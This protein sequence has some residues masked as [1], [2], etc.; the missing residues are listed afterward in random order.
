MGR[1]E[2]SVPSRKAGVLDGGQLEIP[3]VTPSQGS[4]ET[5]LAQGSCQSASPYLSPNLQNCVRAAIQSRSHRVRIHATWL[6]PAEI[7][8][9]KHHRLPPVLLSRQWRG[10]Q[11]HS[12]QES[13]VLYWP[14]FCSGGVD[15][16]PTLC[17]NQR[18]DP[19]TTQ[20]WSGWAS[21][22][23]IK[24]QP[25]NLQVCLYLPREVCGYFLWGSKFR[26]VY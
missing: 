11:G 19:D 14:S 17:A 1:W 23:E 12:D 16:V 20:G 25:L 22:L 26:C 6:Q 13:W 7:T 2:L 4:S 5:S 9:L 10:E 21:L 15:L 8:H 3:S 18:G 24:M